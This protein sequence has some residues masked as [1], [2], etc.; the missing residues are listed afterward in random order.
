ME[1]LYIEACELD[2]GK[3]GRW[4]EI[5]LDFDTLAD[6]KERAEYDCELM[7]CDVTEPGGSYLVRVFAVNYTGDRA[8]DL[9]DAIAEYDETGS[10]GREVWRTVWTRPDYARQGEMEV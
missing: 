4:A 1:R 6:A 9:V 5:N 7:A 8:R 2:D 10:T 3:G